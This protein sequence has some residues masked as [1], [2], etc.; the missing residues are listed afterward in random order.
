MEWLKTGSRIIVTRPIAKGTARNYETI[1]A[2]SAGSIVGLQ[3]YTGNLTVEILTEDG[4]A[5]VSPDLI[6]TP[7]S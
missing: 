6:K 4:F 3:T 5:E 7:N 2:G 1:R